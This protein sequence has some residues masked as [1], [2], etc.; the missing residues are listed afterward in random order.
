MNNTGHLR[1]RLEMQGFCG[2]SDAELA[3]FGPWLRLA[4][5]LCAAWVAMATA[6]GDPYLVWALAP[7]AVLGAALPHHPVDLVYNI[8]VRRLTGTPPVP[9]HHAPRRFACSVAS[10]WLVATGAAF[11]S[12]H[13]A[14][15]YTLGSSMAAAA[16][17]PTL[18]D[19]CV[20]SFI[21]EKIVRRRRYCPAAG[22]T[23]KA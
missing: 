20:P 23:A 15:G 13:D 22:Q 3:G 5:G 18:T 11:Y 10:V 12:G 19:F 14:A 1:R 4:T 7:V 17:I 2:F 21:F 9:A 16:S 6:L 8:A